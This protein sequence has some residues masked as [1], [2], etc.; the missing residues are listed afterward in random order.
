MTVICIVPR[1]PPATDGVGDYALNLARQLRQDH[2]IQTHFIICDRTYSS[3]KNID[4][5]LISQLSDSTSKALLTMLSQLQVNKILLH[6]V[7]YGYAKRGCPTWLVDGLKSWRTANASRK[8]ITMFHEVY[9]ARQPVWTSAFWLFWLQ[10][11]LAADLA[12]LSDRILTSKQ[13][14]S[15]ILSDLSQGK[16]PKVSAI[17]VF[18]NIGEPETVPSLFQRQPWLVVF[19]GSNNRRRAYSES[20]SKISHIC[21][22]FGLEKIIDIGLSTNL[23]LT[24]IDG[25]PLIEKGRLSN[26]EIQKV[27]LKSFVGFLDYNPDYLAK[28]GI[29]A[30][31]S[32]HGMLIINAKG[33]GREIDD[34]ES[35]RNYLIAE[36]LSKNKS[37]IEELQAIANNTFTWY[38]GHKLEAQAEIFIELILTSNKHYLIY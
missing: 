35:G 17:P 33:S 18:S 8:L 14:Y 10:K 3:D 15:E 30:A 19:G 23:K 9:A 21:Q 22:V 38:Q 36:S 7:G 31:Y 2:N 1:L 37:Q 26:E 20:Y 25:I 16:H 29:F 28:S 4:D 6:Y 5:F 34:L 11:K 13:L 24:N 12:K 32:S 27:F